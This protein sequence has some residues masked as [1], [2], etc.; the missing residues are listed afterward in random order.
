MVARE[1]EAP[2]V[3]EH[4]VPARVPRCGDGQEVGF[5]LHWIFTFQEMLDLRGVGVRVVTV[6]NALGAEVARPARVVGHV[7][8]V[9]EE[10]FPYAAQ[11]LDAPYQRPSEA[12]RIDEPVALGALDEVAGGAEGRCRRIT[13]EEDLGLDGLGGRRSW[14]PA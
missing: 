10:E 1:E 4:R 9:G 6:Q 8:D 11:A 3:K 12:R 2:A 13:A 5:D 14:P 7:V